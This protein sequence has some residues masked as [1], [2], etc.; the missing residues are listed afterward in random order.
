MGDFVQGTAPPRLPATLTQQSVST[1]KN[2]AADGD[3]R[4]WRIVVSV[5]RE[6][7]DGAAG[8]GEMVSGPGY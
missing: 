4:L 8:G 3:G 2:G 6:H 7:D 5:G 1:F